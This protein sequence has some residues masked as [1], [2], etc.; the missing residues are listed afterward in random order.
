MSRMW[1][2][3]DSFPHFSTRRFTSLYICLLVTSQ[4]N[5]GS[6]S[7]GSSIP[8]LMMMMKIRN[9]VFPSLMLGILSPLTPCKSAQCSLRICLL[10]TIT[11]FGCLASCRK[12]CEHLVKSHGYRRMGSAPMANSQIHVSELCGEGEYSGRLSVRFLWFPCHFAVRVL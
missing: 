1:R 3:R 4:L 2:F 8:W 5:T 7:F 11:D 10:V 6:R 12:A 9:V